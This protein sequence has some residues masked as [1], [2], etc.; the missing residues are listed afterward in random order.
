MILV[1]ERSA[2]G[3]ASREPG[4]LKAPIR[5]SAHSFDS[6]NLGDEDLMHQ[7]LGYSKSLNKINIAR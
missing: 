3:P 2:I 6:T 1:S 7:S 5:T 4:T